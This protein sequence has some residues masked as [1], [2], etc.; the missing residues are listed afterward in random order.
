VRAV[1]HV[2]MRTLLVVIGC[3]LVVAS[4]MLATLGWGYL[5]LAASGEE[6]RLVTKGIQQIVICGKGSSETSGTRSRRKY[7]A[8]RAGRGAS[9]RTET[10][11]SCA[12]TSQDRQTRSLRPQVRWREALA[13]PETP[14]HPSAWKRNSRKSAS[15]DD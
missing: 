15:P 10:V 7:R 14:I 5:A 6:D 3:F 2:H 13:G 11:E 12:T 4:L 8:P 9:R 1:Y